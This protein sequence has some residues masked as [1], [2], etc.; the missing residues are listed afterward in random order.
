M[1]L[2][3]QEIKRLRANALLV[4]KVSPDT[5]LEITRRDLGDWNKDVLATLQT[6]KQVKNMMLVLLE[7]DKEDQ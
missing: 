6:K 2:L 3:S 7:A 5:R 4:K 1:K